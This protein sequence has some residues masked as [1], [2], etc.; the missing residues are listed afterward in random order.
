M[1]QDMLP[2]G[3]RIHRKNAERRC[4]SVLENG[5]NCL[6]IEDLE[7]RFRKC[8]NVQGI[9]NGMVE[10]L[11]AFL[12]KEL[13]FNH[14]IHFAMNHR[15]K[16][17]LDVALWLAVKVMF[18]IFQKKNQNNG[19]ILR[20][21]VKEIDWNINMNRKLGSKWDLRKLKEI[22]VLKP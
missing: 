17:K 20:E 19:Q 9:Y 10:I 13:E 14:L 6:E 5:Q 15:N 21:M 7:H 18:K 22:L 2:V 16:K 4:M 12:G 3:S 11:E 1:T 8:E